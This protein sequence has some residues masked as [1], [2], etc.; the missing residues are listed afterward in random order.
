MNDPSQRLTQ[1]TV[2]GTTKVYYYFSA[3]GGYEINIDN[4]Y[5]LEYLSIGNTTTAIAT[6]AFEFN[7]EELEYC[8]KM[9]SILMLCPGSKITGNIS[10]L[11]KLTELTGLSIIGNS[12]NITPITGDIASISNLTKLAYNAG[13]GTSD[14]QIILY[15]TNV[16]GSIEDFVAGQVAAGRTQSPTGTVNGIRVRGWQKQFTFGGQVYDIGVPS[17]YNRLIW[18]GTSKIILRMGSS[19]TSMDS[20]VFAKGASANEISEWENQGLTVHIIE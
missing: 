14:N 17:S 16:T 11:S 18:E 20:D 5:E 13:G 3:Q 4:K 8:T 19:Y 15:S 6:T 1:A 12:R 9:K 2:N 10:Y 7:I